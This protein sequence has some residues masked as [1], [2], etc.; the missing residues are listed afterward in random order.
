MDVFNAN[1][2]EADVGVVVLILVA[3]TCCSVSERVQLQD[4]KKKQKNNTFEL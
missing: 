2:L 4:R 3:F 1:K